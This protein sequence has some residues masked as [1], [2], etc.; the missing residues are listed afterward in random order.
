MYFMF[1]LGL[2]GLFRFFRKQGVDSNYWGALV[3]GEILIV[4]QGLLGAYLWIIGGRPERS[5]HI[6]YGIMTALVI[7]AVYAY[8]KGDT[9]RRSM[10]IY[11]IALLISAL[12]IIRAVVTAG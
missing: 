1:L 4:A 10:L 11:G 7:P 12:L 2:W 3:I 6:L 5:I 8:T 9:E